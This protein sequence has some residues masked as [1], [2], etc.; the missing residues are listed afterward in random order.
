MMEIIKSKE[1][2]RE[3]FKEYWATFDI[4]EFAFENSE[5]TFSCSL[6]IYDAFGHSE[7]SQFQVFNLKIKFEKLK[8]ITVNFEDTPPVEDL[9]NYLVLNTK[10]FKYISFKPS[11]T[12]FKLGL[13]FGTSEDIRYLSIEIESEEILIEKGATIQKTA[14]P[15]LSSDVIKLELNEA[16][17]PTAKQI[18]SFFQMEKINVHFTEYWGNNLTIEEI[19]NNLHG[20]NIINSNKSNTEGIQ[21]EIE[22]YSESVKW[23]LSN[24][25]EDETL[26]IVL[27]EKIIPEL[28]FQKVA[29]GIM[30]F[31]KGEWLELIRSSYAAIPRMSTIET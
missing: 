12:E 28:N 13:V 17:L 5:D 16:E 1:E 31:T 23:T 25:T 19:N 3:A 29:C 30:K 26:W 2:L 14:D 11:F 15:F 10:T 21:M 4:E 9:I 6:K 8:K 22:K 27:L 24:F 20:V 18:K 7:E